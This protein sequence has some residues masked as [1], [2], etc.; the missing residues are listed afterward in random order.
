MIKYYIGKLE[1]VNRKIE[2]L[3]DKLELGND[4]TFNEQTALLIAEA[5][6]RLLEEFIEDLKTTGRE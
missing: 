2:R 5:E 6:K 4:I 3:K 1:R